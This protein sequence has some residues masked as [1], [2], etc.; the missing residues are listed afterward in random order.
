MK[1]G[2]R[3]L[4][5]VG[6]KVYVGEV[7]TESILHEDAAK[8]VDLANQREVNFYQKNGEAWGYNIG[9]LPSS[10]Q[11]QLGRGSRG[12]AVKD[13]TSVINGLTFDFWNN[14]SGLGEV[15]NQG[16]EEYRRSCVQAVKAALQGRSGH[17]SVK[18]GG[19]EFEALIQVFLQTIGFEVER[20]ATHS[21]PRGSDVDLVASKLDTFMGDVR[22]FVQVKNHK[23][24]SGMEALRQLQNAYDEL[25]RRSEVQD[26]DKWIIV[27]S[28]DQD[29]ELRKEVEL[30]Y[31]SV[32]VVDG[33]SLAEWVLDE[34][35]R[36]SDEIKQKLGLLPGP[37]TTV[38]Y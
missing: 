32:H 14:P 1:P 20:Q 28:G 9:Q 18:P 13:I 31:P 10:V 15:Y 29:E 37:V 30:R 3:V 34:G 21:L 11:H 35:Y 38:V 24:R 16:V 7:V 33:D 5:R 4:F 2:D 8:G 26:G 27:T 25:S 23:G 6:Q 12:L 22:L 36:L 19:I 17:T